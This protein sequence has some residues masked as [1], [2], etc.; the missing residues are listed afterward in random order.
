[1]PIK[2]GPYGTNRRTFSSTLSA[3]GCSCELLQGVENARGNGINSAETADRAVLRSMFTAALGK[4]GIKVHKGFCLVVVDLQALED[5]I[6]M[7]VF[8]LHE[9]FARH[10]VL[11][12]NLRRVVLDV[13]GAA[14]RRVHARP[15]MRS[16]IS[17]S[18]T[19]IS[20]T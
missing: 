13:I 20:R 18:G 16:T 14:A 5:D 7:V 6:F 1:M 9:I 19:L 10:I 2:K 8:A 3:R 17:A 11:A 15:D 4:L 12:R